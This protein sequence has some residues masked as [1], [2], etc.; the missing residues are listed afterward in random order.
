MRGYQNIRNERLQNII[1]SF[2]SEIAKICEEEN[3]EQ[4]L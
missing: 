4:T 2:L 3:K 1:C